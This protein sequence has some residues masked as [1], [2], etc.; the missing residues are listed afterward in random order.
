L[1]RKR[2]ILLISLLVLCLG[3]GCGKKALPRPERLPIPGGIV[4]FSGEVKDGVLFLSFTMPQKD[5]K[6]AELKDLAGFRIMKSCGTCTG[7][8]FEPF[9][10][11]ILDE[12]QGYTIANGKI[13]V[14]DDDLKNGFQYAYRAYPVTRL[15]NSGD[16]SK[17]FY[18]TWQTPPGPPAR[19]TT[20]GGDGNVELSW[21]REGN[22]LYNVYRVKEGVYPLF[23]ANGSPLS[24][25]RF[26]DAGL[27]NG[28]TFRYE[29]RSVRVIDAV[30]WEGTG[31]TVAAS[32]ADRTRPKA[33]LEVKAGRRGH[34]VMVTWKAGAEEDLAGYNVYR[35]SGGKVAKLN[36][37]PVKDT[38]F[39]DR[40]V[41]D[42]R[43]ASY[44]VTAVDTS[45]NESENSKES[46]IILM[47]E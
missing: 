45:M 41:P 1:K 8:G 27:E 31:I 22:L 26:A 16:S 9:R 47:K 2:C 42:V 7:G 17:V 28:K 38:S 18:I 20:K 36:G 34:G 24:N 10:E 23:P 14:F 5:S 40:K 46:I 30:N 44:Y 25:P 35:V 29:V 6:G 37:E 3:M 39:A 33:P 19:V 12:R 11:I 13:Y 15:G 21:T 4:D 32:T 43:Y